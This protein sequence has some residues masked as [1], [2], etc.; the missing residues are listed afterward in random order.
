MGD[1]I[2][3]NYENGRYGK[4]LSKKGQIISEAVIR[5]IFFVTHANIKD[6]FFVQNQ[7]I[8]LIGLKKHDLEYIYKAN[9]QP[10]WP[11]E[12]GPLKYNLSP[13]VLD[14][15]KFDESISIEYRPMRI[16]NLE[17]LALYPQLDPVLGG[18]IILEKKD[19]SK[20]TIIKRDKVDGQD[21]IYEKDNSIR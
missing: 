20:Q 17:Y 18:S 19:G 4:L 1:K 16:K 11:A 15:Y 7:L 9:W 12:I 13:E 6:E 10:D 2:V 14:N 5:P 8:F 3:T 21:I